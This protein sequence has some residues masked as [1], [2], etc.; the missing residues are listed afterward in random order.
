MGEFLIGALYATVVNNFEDVFNAG[1]F[2]L[3]YPLALT[4]RDKQYWTQVINNQSTA[5]KLGVEVGNAASIVQGIIEIVAGGG[6]FAGGAALCTIGAGATFGISCAAGAPAMVTGAAVSAHGLS[7]IK[8]GLENDTDA[9]L[10]DDLLAPQ[11]ME[12]TGGADGVRGLAKQLGLGGNKDNKVKAGLEVLEPNEFV[13]FKND[14]D[15]TGDDAKNLF[16]PLFDKSESIIKKV[17][18]TYKKVGKDADAIAD[19]QENLSL[20]KTNKRG[21]RFLDDSQLEDAFTQTNQFLDKYDDRVSGAFPNRFGRANAPDLDDVQALGEIKTAEDILDGRTP[22]GDGVKLRG[23]SEITGQKNPEYF[24]TMP[25]GST[26]LVEV[27]TLE[28]KVTRL[29]L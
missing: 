4:D 11:K 10:I 9:N 5:F 14:I 23:L 7:L 6:T 19:I 16:R 18:G 3:Q 17:F 25:D 26:R 2:L 13:Q 27:K 21:R 15:G 1:Q 29:N 8:N 24:A 28:S 20:N 22:L 12:S